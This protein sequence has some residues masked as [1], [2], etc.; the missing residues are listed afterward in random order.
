MNLIGKL[1]FTQECSFQWKNPFFMVSQHWC[2]ATLFQN[3]PAQITKIIE[4]MLAKWNEK[5]IAVSYFLN[6]TPLALP[7]I[8]KGR[9]WSMAKYLWE[10]QFHPCAGFSAREQGSVMPSK[11]FLLSR[12]SKDEI[13]DL[14]NYLNWK[15]IAAVNTVDGSTL[16]DNLITCHQ[17]DYTFS[18]LITAVAVENDQNHISYI[19]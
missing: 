4:V 19:L 10:S 9:S 18:A 14:Q 2:K 16:G 13:K 11:N 7:Y 15:M 3:E 17:V 5:L 12:I 8:K 1:T 6:L